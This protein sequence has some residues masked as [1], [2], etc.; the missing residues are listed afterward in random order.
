MTR[1]HADRVRLLQA[2][3][4]LGVIEFRYAT[5]AP[6][7]YVI[8]P[9]GG[10]VR[11][12]GPPDVIPYVQ[13]LMDGRSAGRPAGQPLTPVAAEALVPPAGWACPRCGRVSYHPTDAVEGYCGAC[14]DW[15]GKPV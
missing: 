15:T 8:G 14:H 1:G 13:G 11:E 10:L 12:L 2:L 3:E 5:T 7:R 9:P 6:H 4:A